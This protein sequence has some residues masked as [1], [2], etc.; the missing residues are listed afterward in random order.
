[1]IIPAR[2]YLAAVA[3]VTAAH[4]VPTL[5]VSAVV[6]STAA[7]S[8]YAD[9]NRKVERAIRKAERTQ[10]R[11]N[12]AQ[13]RADR[14]QARADNK[15]YRADLAYKKAHNAVNRQLPPK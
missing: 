9:E 8:A 1:M 6:A 10:R 12:R 2:N 13:D 14:V 11:A 15:Q 7:T 4:S 3:L 5:V